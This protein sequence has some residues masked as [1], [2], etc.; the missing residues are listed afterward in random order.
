MSFRIEVA[1]GRNVVLLWV[2]GRFDLS[3]GFAVFQCCQPEIQ[4]F[5]LYALNLAGVSDLR[6]AGLSWL[7]MF[8]PW[9]QRAGISVQIID[10]R[11][12]HRQ[13][14]SE[15]GIPVAASIDQ[16]CLWQEPT[17]DLELGVWVQARAREA[18]PR[19]LS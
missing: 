17:L 2:Q 5:R 8:M 15:W 16:P 1:V 12:E 4:P 3:T 6:D 14:Y 13:R 9:G 11:P 7:R 18:G 19:N 10:V